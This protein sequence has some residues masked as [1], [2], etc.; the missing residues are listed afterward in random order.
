MCFLE[1]NISSILPT[2]HVLSDESGIVYVCQYSRIL[3]KWEIKINIFWT[4]KT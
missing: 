1:G 3:I 2:R 4:S